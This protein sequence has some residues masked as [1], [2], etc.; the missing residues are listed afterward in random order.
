MIRS[1]PGI[2]DKN[3]K[4]FEMSVFTPNLFQLIPKKFRE[5]FSFSD[6]LKLIVRVLRGYRL[7]MVTNGENLCAYT[8]LKRNYLHKYAF[9]RRGDF[10]INP[11]YVH[12]DNRSCGIARKMIE[13]VMN[14]LPDHH[15]RVWAVVK[16][17]NLPSLSVLSKCGFELVGYSEKRL[18]SHCLTTEK[19]HLH[20]F[21]N[22]KL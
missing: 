1:L 12:P 11:Y 17:D 18:W 4:S 22:K 21:S 20:L 10:L 14:D 2:K 13:H 6:R 3:G 9:M 7:Y 19:T 16:N 5:E 8:F 15:G